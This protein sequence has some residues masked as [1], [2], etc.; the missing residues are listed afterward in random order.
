MDRVKTYAVL[1]QPLPDGEGGGW[2]AAVPDLPG[3]MSDG[4]TM[5]QAASNIDGAIESW[6]EAAE[7]LGRPVPAPGS[8]IGQWRQRVPKTLHQVL[9]QIAASEG[10]SLNSLVQSILAE[11][12]GRREGI[13][14]AK[15][16]DNLG[17]LVKASLYGGASPNVPSASQ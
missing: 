8:T 15:S 12:V 4:E 1:I 11:S 17:R 7:E 9:K 6:F 5:E 10:V 3:C 14:K 16:P 13:T 2:V